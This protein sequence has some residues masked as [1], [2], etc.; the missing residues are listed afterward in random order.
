MLFIDADTLS[1]ASMPANIISYENGA[2]FAVT[3]TVTLFLYSFSKMYNTR[4]SLP[5]GPFPLPL[6]G[7]LL[8]LIHPKLL[9]TEILSLIADRYGPVCTLFLGNMPSIV[10]TDPVIG[11]RLLKK[12]STSGRGPF[13][14]L[15]RAFLRGHIDVILSDNTPE[16]AAVKKVFQIGM[17]NIIRNP[18][19]ERNVIHAVDRVMDKIEDNVVDSDHALSLMVNTILA[20]AGFSQKYEFED[21]EFV[22]WCDY[23]KRMA[24]NASVLNTVAINPLLRFVYWRQW[25]GLLA[26][27]RDLI[28]FVRVIYRRALSEDRQEDTSFCHAFIRAKEEAAGKNDKTMVRAMDEENILNAIS[29]LFIA[30]TETTKTTLKWMIILM[31]KYPEIQQRMREEIKS[32]IVSAEPALSH[33]SDCHLVNAFMREVMRF[34]PNIGITAH[35]VISDEEINGCRIT[36]GTMII[37]VLENFMHDKKAWGDPENFRPERFL[38]Q[39]GKFFEKKKDFFIPF[40]DGRRVCPGAQLAMNNLFLMTA[41]LLQTTEGIA[42]PGGVTDELLRGDVNVTVSLNPIPFKV[43]LLRNK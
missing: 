23:M 29:D 18:E 17:K 1:P 39:D 34:R 43:R 3:F 25:N 40:S 5:P 4:R 12:N 42:I 35:K 28:Q 26:A 16:W 11:L 7:N 15:H 9:A 24:D 32:V 14:I 8:S 30:G 6:I 19:S 22:S 33:R 38:D 37:F 31:C 20:E 27:S 13:D 21:E 41:R 10:V 36:K 2:V